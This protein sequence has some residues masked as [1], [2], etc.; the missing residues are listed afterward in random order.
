[1]SDDKKPI[2]KLNEDIK[3]LEEKTGGK[4]EGLADKVSSAFWWQIKN[5]IIV[6]VTG[7]QTMSHVFWDDVLIKPVSFVTGFFIEGPKNIKPNDVTRMLQ[8]AS[9]P[10]SEEHT[11]ELQSH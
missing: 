8:K 11:S 4:L 6:V 5:F 3:T 2:E 1:M 10:R 7:M 9:T